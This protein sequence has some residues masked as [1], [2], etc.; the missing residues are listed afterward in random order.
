MFL[1]VTFTSLAVILT[2]DIL[3]TTSFVNSCHETE[4]IPPKV[5]FPTPT[6][7]AAPTINV[8]AAAPTL[9]VSALIVFMLV[10]FISAVNLLATLLTTTPAPRALLLEPA[11][12]KAPVTIVLPLLL[13][14]IV[15]LSPSPDT[16]V[17]SPL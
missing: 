14:S 2:P 5:S 7:P 6:P 17:S 16:P 4:P 10:P 11:T 13:F 1:L 3:L 9:T 15:A 12:D 8:S